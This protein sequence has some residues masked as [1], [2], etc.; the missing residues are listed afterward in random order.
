MQKIIV[1]TDFSTTA[2]KA[3]TYAAEIAQKSLSTLCLLN[4]AE[5][6]SDSMIEPYPWHEGMKEEFIN[7]KLEKLSSIE[8][9]LKEIYPG[10]KIETE[11][12]KGAVINS[13]LDFAEGQ[14]ADL[15]VMGTTGASGLK[16]IFMGSVAAGTI[17]KT[18]I[19]ALT[20]PVSYE[21]EEP[22]A[23]LFATNRFEENK[24]LLKPHS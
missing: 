12:A 15:I 13:I 9:S 16:E 5:P 1:P 20:V 24:E 17:G 6:I 18:K 4:V 23:I 21:M 11:V 19:P 2:M 8:Q 3:V 10:I 7:N 22:D 14:Q